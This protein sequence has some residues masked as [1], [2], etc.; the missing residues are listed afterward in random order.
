M[1]Q[2]QTTPVTHQQVGELRFAIGLGCIPRAAL[3]VDVAGV[4]GRSEGVCGGRDGDHT[5]LLSRGAQVWQERTRQSKVRDVA[6]LGALLAATHGTRT[7]W[8][9]S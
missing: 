7:L 2:R 5:R 4:D 8:V 3:P 1:V 6:D 9:N